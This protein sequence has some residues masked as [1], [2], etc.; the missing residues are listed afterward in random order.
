MIAPDQALLVA[1]SLLII[2]GLPLAILGATRGKA[3]Q[4]GQLVFQDEVVAP[5]FRVAFRASQSGVALIAIGAVLLIVAALIAPP[6][7]YSP[8]GVPD[9]QDMKRVGVW[10]R[11]WCRRH[12][13][14]CFLGAREPVN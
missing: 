12:R 3:S 11:L 7:N 4:R 6:S 10:D 14:R 9:P 5:G 2:A 1:G 13:G 8:T